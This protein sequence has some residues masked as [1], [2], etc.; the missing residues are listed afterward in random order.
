MLRERRV[1]YLIQP[2]Y[3]NVGF[4]TCFCQGEFDN[5]FILSSIF[6]NELGY[7]C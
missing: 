2:S 4:L 1:N 3:E 6:N 5:S 7:I